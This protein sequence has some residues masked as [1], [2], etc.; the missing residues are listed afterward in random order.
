MAATVRFTAE[1]GIPGWVPMSNLRSS[2]SA[3]RVLN[4]SNVQNMCKRSRACIIMHQLATHFSTDLVT[5]MNHATNSLPLQS[6]KRTLPKSGQLIHPMLLSENRVLHSILCPNVW[7]NV[8]QELKANDSI[9]P[10]SN[11][12]T[13]DISHQICYMSWASFAISICVRLKIGVPG[14]KIFGQT[15]LNSGCFIE[16]PSSLN[17]FIPN[18]LNCITV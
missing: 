17:M 18:K 9:E 6:L 4:G 14:S 16:I 11:G 8:P 1:I 15:R 3:W 2:S 13:P 5:I 7:L 12:L 10:I